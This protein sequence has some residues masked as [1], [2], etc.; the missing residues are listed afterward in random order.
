MWQ[1]RSL[2]LKTKRKWCDAFYQ[3]F[4]SRGTWCASKHLHRLFFFFFGNSNTP[5]SRLDAT[6]MFELHQKDEVSQPVILQCDRVNLRRNVLIKQARSRLSSINECVKYNF[7][8]KGKGNSAFEYNV[9]K[10]EHHMFFYSFPSSSTVHQ[11]ASLFVFIVTWMLV[12]PLCYI[13]HILQIKWHLH[14]PCWSSPS[15][16]SVIISHCSSFFQSK[17]LILNTESFSHSE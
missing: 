15:V 13:Q 7:S 12:D 1:Q 16:D 9:V 4:A 2:S 11:N 14:C 6:E 3:Q 10:L 17:T 5:A 8:P